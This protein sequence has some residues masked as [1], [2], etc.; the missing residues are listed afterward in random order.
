MN[1]QISSISKTM[2]AKFGLSLNT[3]IAN[4]CKIWAKSS[5][6]LMVAA[7]IS[8][9]ALAVVAIS[10]GFGD[11]DLNNNGIALEDVDVSVQGGVGSTTYIPGRV[12]VDGMS[13]EP[14]NMEIDSVLDAS[15]TGVRWLQMRGWS[16]GPTTLPNAGNSKPT[17]R[18][19]DDSAGAMLETQAPGSGG[20]GI[21]AIDDGNAMSWE[22]RGGGASAAAFFGQNIALGSVV[23]DE[24][25]VSFDFRMWRDA[26]NTNSGADGDNEADFGELRFGLYQDTDGQLAN[27]DVNPF[28]GRQ[29][30]SEGL[31]LPDPNTQFVPAVWGQEEGMFDGT[32]TGTQGTGDDVGTNGDN[33]WQA[34]VFFGDALFDDGGG[35]R[36]REEMQSD[37]ILQGGDVQTI[38]QPENIAMG[39][40]FDPPEFDFVNLDLD[41]VFT[42]ELSLTRATEVT[43]G[44]TIAAELIL[45][46]KNTLETWSLSGQDDLVSGLDLAGI[47]S[48]SWDYFA[49]RNASS[50]G[51]EFDF[52]LDN[53]AVEVN[54]SNEGDYI[55]TGLDGDFNDDGTVDA[56]DYTVYRDNLGL[57]DAALNGNG[58]GSGTVSLADYN[59]WVSSYGTSSSSSA[60][61]SVPEPTS[62]LL[63][64]VAGALFT[65]KRRDQ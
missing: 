30:D 3:D 11:A 59:L 28:A 56:A 27:G 16:D 24:V 41:G 54:G 33:G 62:L 31:P 63:L 50:G 65:L 47:N 5:A 45:T 38:A 48:E 60:A 18:I 12:F 22:S 21:T 40:P 42:I 10:D 43:A 39:G 8:T 19:V 49:L 34:S 17:L 37:R 9:P 53:F 32:L 14:T 57:S 2:A 20:L 55:P 64:G 51:G 13:S 52:I 29:V 61:S 58:T 6:A 1:H 4:K 23:G 44:D 25:K 46:D 35:T 36:I 26:P 7:T 15:D